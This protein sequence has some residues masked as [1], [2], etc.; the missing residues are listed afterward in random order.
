MICLPNSWITSS[1]LV[2]I[3][4]SRP[5]GVGPARR[6]NKRFSPSDRQYSGSNPGYAVPTVNDARDLVRMLLTEPG[7]SYQ[8]PEIH[9]GRFSP[10]TGIQYQVSGIPW[11]SIYR[12][13]LK[14]HQSNLYTLYGT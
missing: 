14:I 4:G 9:R 1:P 5:A 11:S 6:A 7:I 12:Y 10:N 2:S 8:M 3:C 13:V